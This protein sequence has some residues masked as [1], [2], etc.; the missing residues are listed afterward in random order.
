MNRSPELADHEET[1]T[2]GCGWVDVSQR[3]LI[4]VQGH[5]RTSFLHNLTTNDIRALKTD[6][7]CETFLAN[8]QGRIV[9]HGWVFCLSDQLW[10]ATVPGQT[11][12]LISHLDR[13][14][15]REDV[16]LVDR[17]GRSSQLLLA[18][19]HTGKSLAQLGTPPPEVALSHNR[20]VLADTPVDAFHVPAWASHATLLVLPSGDRARVIAALESVGVTQCAAEAVE[21]QRVQAAFPAYGQDI[22]TE[23]LPQEV[24]RDQHA[25]SFTKGCY[26]G[27]ETVARIDALGHVNRLLK[28]LSWDDASELPP[29]AMPLQCEGKTVG[30]VTSVCWGSAAGKAVGLGYV[31][32]EHSSEGTELDTDLGPARVIPPRRHAS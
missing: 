10:L 27:Q 26:L 8:V 30:Q 11:N 1:L 17:A 31:R 18:G 4:E 2:R 16:K 21:S 29:V 28:S 7:G 6:S 14:L 3:T 24:D 5:D 9:G 19:P 13:Y 22:S 20:L 23:N 15:I 32:R 12:A 25:I